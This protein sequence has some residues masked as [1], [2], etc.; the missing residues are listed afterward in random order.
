MSK[1][2][3]IFLLGSAV[4]I[5]IGCGVVAYKAFNIGKDV[6]EAACLKDEATDTDNKIEI[7]QK[8]NEIRNHHPDDAVTTR[9][10][11]AHTF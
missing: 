5:L 1:L 8:Q 6:K 11:L 10:L 4:A 3:L 7:R 9:R 2:K